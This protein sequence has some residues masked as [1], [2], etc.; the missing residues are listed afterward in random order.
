MCRYSEVNILLGLL[1]CAPC[2]WM[3]SSQMPH[4]FS[5][6]IA[7]MLR[8][9]LVPT[10]ICV[11]SGLLLLAGSGLLSRASAECSVQPEAV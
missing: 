11:P 1:L 4:K 8:T 5:G 2:V 3:S 6:H 10:I 7:D 9:L